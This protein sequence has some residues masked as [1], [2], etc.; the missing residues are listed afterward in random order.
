MGRER[1]GEER[2]RIVWGGERE[3]YGGGERGI[4]WGRGEVSCMGEGEGG[5][6]SNR[7]GR[8]ES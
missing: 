4:V 1:D 3:L 5:E 7:D 6:G 2:G 8:V